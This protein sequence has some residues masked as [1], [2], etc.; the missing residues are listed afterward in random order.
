MAN[1]PSV[2]FSAKPAVFKNV[3]IDY[4]G[5]FQVISG[6]KQIQRYICLI[7]CLV[8]RAVHLE[9]VT[10]L[11]TEKCPMAIGRFC[12]RRGSPEVIYSGNGTNF[13]GAANILHDL[14]RLVSTRSIEYSVERAIWGQD[15]EV[16]S[17]YLKTHQRRT[18]KPAH[19]L[20]HITSSQETLTPNN[21]QR[22]HKDHHQSPMITEMCSIYMKEF[23]YTAKRGAN[24]NE[25]SS[26]SFIDSNDLRLFNE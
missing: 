13:Q 16:R 5:P 17:C 23:Y 20:S 8:G 2:R 11:S 9:T 18:H 26:M 3:G 25:T 14:A 7:T 21:R 12:S 10:D 24:V 19:L 4:C 1:L 15:G 6:K 22:R